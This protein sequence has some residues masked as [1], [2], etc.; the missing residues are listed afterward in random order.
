MY[1]QTGKRP[2]STLRTH[3]HE[4]GHPKV[5]CD[6]GQLRKSGFKLFFDHV[7]AISIFYKSKQN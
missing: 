7:D 5:V 6:I 2:Y 3:N 1:G 4:T